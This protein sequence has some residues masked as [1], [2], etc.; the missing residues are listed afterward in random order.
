MYSA[1][2]K[3]LLN[4]YAEL[5]ILDNFIY[6]ILTVTFFITSVLPHNSSALII[7]SPLFPLLS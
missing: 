3:L 1:V 2:F 7:F 4:L 6:G 5:L